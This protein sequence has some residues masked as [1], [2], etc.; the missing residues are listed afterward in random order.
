MTAA[1]YHLATLMRH[2]CRPYIVTS[3]WWVTGEDIF[4]PRNLAYPK[5]LAEAVAAELRN[6]QTIRVE[7]RHPG[8]WVEWWYPDG[9]RER[10]HPPGN[11]ALRNSKRRRG[12]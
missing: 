8:G 4:N 7:V 11:P 6:P 1:A 5:T 2:R 10:P 12:K 3:W 9:R